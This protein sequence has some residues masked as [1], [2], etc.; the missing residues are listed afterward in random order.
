MNGNIFHYKIDKNWKISRHSFQTL[1]QAGTYLCDKGISI[2]SFLKI[3]VPHDPNIGNY[4]LNKVTLRY[5]HTSN[6]F[7]KRY[8]SVSHLEKKMATHSRILAWKFHGQKSLAGYSPW[9]RKR[10][11]QD[12]EHTHIQI[13]VGLLEIN[14]YGTSV[15]L[16]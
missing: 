2:F 5:R 1:H 12:R 11:K 7:W 10:V 15:T 8:T 13:S 4:S 14:S 16:R 6:F 3:K 9:G